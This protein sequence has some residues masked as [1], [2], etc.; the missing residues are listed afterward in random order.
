MSAAFVASALTRQTT[1]ADASKSDS[2]S[3]ALGVT[4]SRSHI[5]AMLATAPTRTT[6]F[7]AVH[8]KTM[9]KMKRIGSTP[10]INTLQSYP[11]EFP[12]APPAAPGS[13]CVRR[14]VHAL[15]VGGVLR[16]LLLRR[17]IRFLRILLAVTLLIV[18][19]IRLLIPLLLVGLLI[20]AR[21][22]KPLLV[23]RLLLIRL[24]GV[25][26]LIPLLLIALPIRLLI[27]LLTVWLLISLLTVWLLV[28][29]LTIGL[30]IIRIPL[31][32]ILRLPIAVCG[33]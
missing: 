5:A 13:R 9:L 19:R 4:S 8:A 29:L 27:T 17:Q 10:N 30:L 20:P 32:T 24:L 15:T 26:L 6:H 31:L 25:W 28:S 12:C 2:T 7:T 21:L 23:I 16:V 11:T 22:H 18:R 14:R 33:A 3:R 1:A